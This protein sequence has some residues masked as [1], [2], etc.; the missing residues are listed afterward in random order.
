MH[1]LIPD[2]KI[3]FLLRNP[4]DR[5]WSHYKLCLKLYPEIAHE[6]KSIDYI[7]EFLNRTTQELRSDY[8]R[9]ISIYKMYFPA[10]QIMIGFYDAI[11]DKP[12][13]LLSNIVG[14]LDGDTSAISRECNL[15][16]KDNVSPEVEMP[17]EV[18]QFLESKYMPMLKRL[19]ENFGSYC[20]KWYDDAI[21]HNYKKRDNN[22]FKPT[23][24]LIAFS[25]D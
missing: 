7:I 12:E 17:I 5:A 10:N 3:I 4:I 11:K 1:D 6:M 19:S 18:R 23:Q 20:T 15:N 25:E 21:R 2:V 22:I 24:N 16:A 13:H 9:T 8:F 14:F